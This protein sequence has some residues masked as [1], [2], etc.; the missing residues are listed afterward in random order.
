MKIRTNTAERGIRADSF[1]GGFGEVSYDEAMV[2][3]ARSFDRHA[4]EQ[5][6]IEVGRFKPRNICR[7]LKEML[8]QRKN[9]ADDRRGEDSVA[10][11]QRTLDPDHFPIVTV[12]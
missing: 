5:R 7:N 10:Y 8:E 3:C 9:A 4:A 2:I 6:M 1:G 11:G 12:R